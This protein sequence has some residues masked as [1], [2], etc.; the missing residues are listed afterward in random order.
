[1]F[2]PVKRAL[3]V[4]VATAALCSGQA[5][6][7]TPATNASL[8]VDFG[9]VLFDSF[10]IIDVGGPFSALNLL[11]MRHPMNLHLIANTLDPVSTKPRS[12]A[13]N[14]HNS[15][16]S[17]SLVPTHTFSNPP[18]KLD[19]LFVPGGLGSRSPDLDNQIKFIRETYPK[20]QYLLSICTG[21]WLTARAGVLDNRNATSNK[22]SWA[23]REG[24]GNNTNW[25][26]HARWVEDGNVWTSSGVAAGID[27]TLA[28]MEKVYGNET[29]TD[30]ANGM[31][32]LRVLNSTYDPFADLYGL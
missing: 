19:V 6:S 3:L 8:P 1:M 11:S 28:W 24:L 13:M 22:R 17:Q 7:S 21:A 29:A 32:Y 15:N 25:I 31:E 5:N 9:I 14:P 23:G 18:E 26:T 4:L 27:A 10:D 2:N 30:I 20:V 16:F 12:A